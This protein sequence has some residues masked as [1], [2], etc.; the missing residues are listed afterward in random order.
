MSTDG[1]A[2]SDGTA[3]GDGTARSALAGRPL[4]ERLAAFVGRPAGEALRAPDPVNRPMIRHWVEAMGD[5]NPVYV[6]DDEARGQGLPGVI[7][8]PTMLQAWIMRGLRTTLEVEA[9]RAA[10]RSGGTSA[11]DQIMGLLDEAGFTS[12]VA[13][14]CEQHYVRPLVPGDH[15]EV[16]S[17]IDSVSAEKTTALGTG[18][19]LTTRLEFS[20]QAGEVVGSMLFRILKFRPHP[21]T[22]P[23]EGAGGDAARQA[24]RPL[25]PRP[26]LTDDN[27]FF[28][29]GTKGGA[30][31]VQRC[32]ACGTLR[33]PPRPAC[34]RCRSFEW[35]TVEA[36][37]RG[38]IFSF[39]VNHHPQVPAFD[40]PLVVALVEL[41]EGTRLVANVSGI[42]PD[43]V[44]I[45]MAVEARV[46]H[47]DADLALPVF[48]PAPEGA[49]A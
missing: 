29:D 47:F 27:R 2:G 19:F 33:H 7:A 26:L 18:H 35:D 28:F 6:D 8:P 40:Y 44:T 43:E 3:G 11:T 42:A 31:L 17:V 24:D 4:A 15:L 38:R 41:E 9:A 20:D 5:E 49:G 45:G 10:G 21:P 13:T 39:V 32:R 36:S 14:N 22:G 25:R 16:R 46:E 48:V 34:G 12:V 23:G 30:L 1:S 37:G